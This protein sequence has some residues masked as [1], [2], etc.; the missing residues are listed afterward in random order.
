MRNITKLG[1]STKVDLWMCSCYAGSI[2]LFISNKFR[3]LRVRLVL[4]ALSL[5]QNVS[6]KWNSHLPI[7]GLRR[8]FFSD[9]MDIPSTSK[10]R[11]DLVHSFCVAVKRMKTDRDTRPAG[12][13][14]QTSETSCFQSL[15]LRFCLCKGLKA[16]KRIRSFVILTCFVSLPKTAPWNKKTESGTKYESKAIKHWMSFLH[17]MFRACWQ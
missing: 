3:C 1:F 2:E 16:V 13:L 11:T 7:A 8:F 15:G 9:Q 10:A 4:C 6:C 14:M 17:W 12:P 5:D